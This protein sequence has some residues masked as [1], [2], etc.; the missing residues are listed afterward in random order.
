MSPSARRTTEHV[1]AG[2][3]GL[4]KNVFT[5]EGQPVQGAYY[6]M[7][8][9]WLVTASALQA[10]Y[11]APLWRLLWVGSAFVVVFTAAAATMAVLLARR[12]LLGL[13]A[14]SLQAEALR[15][16]E[17]VEPPATSILEFNAVIRIIHQTAEDIRT[18]DRHRELLFHELNHRVKNTLAT[19]QSLARRTFR[20]E[21]PTL[22]RTFEDRLIA[23]SASHTLLAAENWTGTNVRSM[24]ARLRSTVGEFSCPAAT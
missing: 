13:R 5:L 17:V 10:V 9:G 16:I 21:V 18:R 2:T 15:K 12:I 6:R 1:P 20:T 23:L 22:Y 11:E 24:S 3:I 14:L 7:P 19:V 4:W 8:Q